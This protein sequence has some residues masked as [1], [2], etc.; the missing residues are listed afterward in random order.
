MVDSYLPEE[1]LKA[2]IDSLPTRRLAAG[3][4]IRND[5]G[6]MLVVKPNYKDGWTIPGGT[7]EAGE[8]PQAGCFREVAE[9][10]GLDLEPGRLLVI[11]HGLQMGIWGDSTYYIYDAGVLPATTTITL[12]EEELTGYEWVAPEDLDDYF[13]PRHAHRLRQ[14]FRAVQTGAVYEFSSERSA[15]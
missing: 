5:E 8:A 4:L 11:F 1:E 15:S 13:G 14:A 7:V 3:A 10:V 9:E 6:K 2:F 12:Q